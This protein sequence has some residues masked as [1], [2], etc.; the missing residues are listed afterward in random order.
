MPHCWFIVSL[1]V[2]LT[3]LTVVPTVVVITIVTKDKD[4][5]ARELEKDLEISGSQTE[6][7]VGSENERSGIETETD[8]PGWNRRLTTRSPKIEIRI[9]SRKTSEAMAVISTEG[10]IA[11]TRA[12]V[13]IPPTSTYAK[14]KA[15]YSDNSQTSEAVKTTEN[16]EYVAEYDGYYD[17]EKSDHESSK[18]TR[19]GIPPSSTYAKTKAQY[20]D[21]FQTSTAI[22]TTENVEYVAEY[23]GYYDYEKSDHEAFFPSEEGKFTTEEIPS[24]IGTTTE[25]NNLESMTSL[26]SEETPIERISSA[27]TTQVS[28]FDSQESGVNHS[29]SN[30]S[31]TASTLTK[32]EAATSKPAYP[33]SFQR[34][35]RLEFYIYKSRLSKIS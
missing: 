8:H 29:G 7:F 28:K 35:F 6:I 22:K 13:G 23:G 26:K 10:V 12:T 21:N 25:N 15:Q 27:D 18:T 5:L 17:Y 4:D 31:T 32:T 14:T 9:T 24:T 20:S 2:C 16:V 3:I 19:V 33:E 1:A 34:C 11:T 30:F